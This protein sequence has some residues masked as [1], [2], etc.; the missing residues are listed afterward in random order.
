MLDER[1]DWAQKLAIDP[2]IA[3]PCHN[4]SAHG[5]QLEQESLVTDHHG[6]MHSERACKVNQV[7]WAEC[8]DHDLCELNSSHLAE[9][10]FTL[11]SLCDYAVTDIVYFMT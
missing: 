11:D 10:F 5:K 6:S 9:N 8:P 1:I 2:I 7:K 4:T 3:V